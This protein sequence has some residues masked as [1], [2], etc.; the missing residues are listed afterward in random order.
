MS[1]TDLLIDMDV[2]FLMPS[3]PVA[4][5]LAWQ[6]ACSVVRLCRSADAIGRAGAAVAISH[7]T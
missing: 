4:A 7:R 5:F 3:L 2:L 1:W 6:A